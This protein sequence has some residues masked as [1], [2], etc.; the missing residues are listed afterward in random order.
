M[1]DSLPFFEDVKDTVEAVKLFI[2]VTES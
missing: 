2:V 1:L